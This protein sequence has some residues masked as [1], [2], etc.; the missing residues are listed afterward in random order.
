M[1]SEAVGL[2]VPS[3]GA[4]VRVSLSQVVSPTATTVG[5]PATFGCTCKEGFF[6]AVGLI[7]R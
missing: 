6:C 4:S 3:G 1:A 7:L 5:S 2:L